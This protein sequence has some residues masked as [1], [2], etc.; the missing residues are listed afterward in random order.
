MGGKLGI[1]NGYQLIFKYFG[2]IPIR[3]IDFSNPAEKAQHD[4]LI[5]L[6]D[7]ILELQKKHHEARME[8]DKELYERQIQ[9]VDAQIDRMVYDLYG[10]TVGEIKVVER[11][12]VRNEK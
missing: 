1:Q 11:G 8:P 10:L 6:V 7:D 5:A 2:K 4:K 9:I 12:W 3:T